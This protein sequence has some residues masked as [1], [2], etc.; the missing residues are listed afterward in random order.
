MFSPG[1]IRNIITKQFVK[2]YSINV[3]GTSLPGDFVPSLE[4]P[5]ASPEE[6]NSGNGDLEDN[7][8]NE[9]NPSEDEL[10]E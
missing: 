8:D 5:S 10:F 9:G 7:E 1:N 6:Q 4:A 2:Y 3:T